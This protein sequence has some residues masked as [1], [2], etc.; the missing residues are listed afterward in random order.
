MSL[1][2]IY[3]ERGAQTAPR[4]SILPLFSQQAICTD[5]DTGR[6]AVGYTIPKSCFKVIK[7]NRVR[8]VIEKPR[9]SLIRSLAPVEPFSETYEVSKSF[10]T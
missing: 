2:R 8:Y 3:K 1:V 6:T 10:F 5:R 4:S 9:R 7:A